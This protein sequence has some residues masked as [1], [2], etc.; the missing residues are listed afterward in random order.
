M[1]IILVLILWKAL[2]KVSSPYNWTILDIGY[3]SLQ[4][5]SQKEAFLP[6]EKA[7]SCSPLKSFLSHPTKSMEPWNVNYRFN[8]VSLGVSGFPIMGIIS[9][10]ALI[11]MLLFALVIR[12]ITFLFYQTFILR[13][14]SIIY[15]SL[16]HLNKQ[17]LSKTS[18]TRDSYTKKRNKCNNEQ[19]YYVLQH[20]S[21]ISFFILFILV[22]YYW[23]LKPH[24]TL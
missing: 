21:S 7:I 2:Q 13:L 11:C 22:L 1:A 12:W 4:G 3:N 8:K 9:I 19:A 14:F 24:N 18:K 10:T 6:I 5:S 23:L 17:Y 15:T 20:A 16:W